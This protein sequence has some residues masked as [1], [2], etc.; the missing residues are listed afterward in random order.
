MEYQME[1]KP[2]DISM[3]NLSQFRFSITNKCLESQKNNNIMH[4]SKYIQ[5]K[6]AKTVNEN[7]TDFKVLYVC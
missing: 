1:T 5:A 4:Y 3:L 6:L 7:E 2:R